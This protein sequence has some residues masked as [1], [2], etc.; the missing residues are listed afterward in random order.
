MPEPNLSFTPD[1]TFP[2]T[3]AEKGVLQVVL[4][5]S[6]DSGT[7]IKIKGGN[8]F[9]SV[10]EKATLE[11]SKEDGKKIADSLSVFNKGKDYSIEMDI[12]CFILE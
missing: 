2:V 11:I 5:K 8:A 10:A 3:F 4:K 1:S 7:D 9:N 12:I 6:Y